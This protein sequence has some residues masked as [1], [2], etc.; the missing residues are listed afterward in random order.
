MDITLDGIES[1]GA[2]SCAGESSVTLSF[3][4]FPVVRVHP[5]DSQGRATKPC[6][7]SFDLDVHLEDLF[8][9]LVNQKALFFLFHWF[10]VNNFHF[11]IIL[12]FSVHTS[13]KGVCVRALTTTIL[14]L[15][16]PR[17]RPDLNQYEFDFGVARI[18]ILGVASHFE[19]PTHHRRDYRQVPPRRI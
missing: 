11:I 12:F 1:L 9:T 2:Q 8:L 16:S 14:F 5:Q 13:W 3:H 17:A 6:I 19:R 18:L 4:S 10:C 7:H 15:I